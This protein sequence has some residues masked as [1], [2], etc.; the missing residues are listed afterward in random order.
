[1]FLG[2]FDPFRLSYS[3]GYCV[4]TDKFDVIGGKVV[5]RQDYK[6]KQLTERREKL[7]KNIKVFEDAIISSTKELEEL[8]SELKA[9]KEKAP[10]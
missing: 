1:M 5:E 8:K 10:N 9:L 7:E 4:D 2:S 3:Y 6:E